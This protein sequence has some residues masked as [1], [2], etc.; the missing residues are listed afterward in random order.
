VANIG[1][2]QSMKSPF[3]SLVYAFDFRAVYLHMKKG[4]W[5]ATSDTFAMTR[6]CGS[7]FFAFCFVTLALE[8]EKWFSVYFVNLA[9]FSISN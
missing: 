8:S 2:G 5:A 3:F 6:V 1:N 9:L 4:F 7:N